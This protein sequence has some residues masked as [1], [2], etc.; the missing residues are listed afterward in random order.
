MR[1]NEAL[2]LRAEI[3][4][5]IESLKQRIERNA[6]VQEGDQPTEQPTA[7]FEE[8]E[9]TLALFEKLLF[10]INKANLSQTLSDNTPLT[11]PLAR[12]DALVQRHRLTTAAIEHAVKSPDV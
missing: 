3:Q 8:A 7:L 12:R 4:R 10:P 6:V 9:R 1:L 11:Q 5:K 2:L